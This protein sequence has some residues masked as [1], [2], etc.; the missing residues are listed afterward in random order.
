M[1]HVVTSVQETAGFF[2]AKKCAAH[3]PRLRTAPPFGCRSIQRS[4]PE[5][6]GILRFGVSPARSLLHAVFSV[7]KAKRRRRG[8]GCSDVFQAEPGFICALPCAGGSRFSGF[9]FRVWREFSARGQRPPRPTVGTPPALHA[10]CGFWYIPPALSR[11]WQR[12][13]GPPVTISSEFLEKINYFYKI[14]WLF[15][16]AYDI[17]SKNHVLLAKWP[18]LIQMPVTQNRFSASIR[19]A[20]LLLSRDV[21]ILCRQRPGTIPPLCGAFWP[22]TER[23]LWSRQR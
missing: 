3:C 4:R 18:L 22:G 13:Q 20:L 14:I 12:P 6:A 1:L 11:A 9:R 23:V 8:I 2:K 16:P 10:S 19:Q 5:K 17:I 21:A 15:V 7:P